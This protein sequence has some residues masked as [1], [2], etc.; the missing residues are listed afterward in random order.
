[1][2]VSSYV[3]SGNFSVGPDR[4]WRASGDVDVFFRDLNV[5]GVVL[6]GHDRFERAGPPSQFTA[7]SIEAN[8]VVK[9][10]A[11]GILR[12]DAVARDGAPDI[13]RLVPGVALAIRANVRVVADW[14]LY[15]DT[16]F[17]GVRA[18]SGNRRARIRLDFV[19]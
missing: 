8:Y 4:F 14:E 13:V 5:S 18:R 11:V 19:F 2:G 1:M 9:P 7:A 3:G 6:V 15:G 10:W 16:E 17:A 12:Y